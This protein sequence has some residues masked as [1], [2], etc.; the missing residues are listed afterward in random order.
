MNGRPWTRDEDL[1][2]LYLKETYREQLKLTHPA[3]AELAGVTNRNRDAIWMR[4]LQL[5]QPR[6]IGTR[7]GLDPYRPANEGRVGSL[8]AP[9][10]DHPTSSPRRLSEAQRSQRRLPIT[11]PIV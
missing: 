7:P 10:G 2:V 9:T 8:S 3:L 6:S 11:T 5:R 1:A 4:K